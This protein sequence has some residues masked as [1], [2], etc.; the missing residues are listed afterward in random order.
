MSQA[1]SEEKKQQWKEDILKQ[2]ESGLSIE[3]WCRTNNIAAHTFHYWQQK[4]FPKILDRS[5]F[6]EISDE[7]VTFNT[8]GAGITV[9]V[10]K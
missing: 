10:Q 7:N 9:L 2:R 1:F 5:T 3:K 4:L 6:T 8:R